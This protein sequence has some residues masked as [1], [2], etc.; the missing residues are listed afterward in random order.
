MPLNFS[1]VS[2]SHFSSDVVAWAQT[3]G[4]DFC[5][6]GLAFPANGVR[7][8][9]A[10]M[11]NAFSRWKIAPNGFGHYIDVKVGSLWVVIGKGKGG[12]DSGWNRLA[13][14][15]LYGENFDP[16]NV[17]TDVWDLEAVVLTPGM[18]LY[19]SFSSNL[20]FISFCR[21]T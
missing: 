14:I 7:W 21:L 17:N 1:G 20:H 4:E 10:S 13:D 2:S 9:S 5:D 19:G 3:E 8:G 12:G 16:Y 15:H 11:K 6:N 18:R